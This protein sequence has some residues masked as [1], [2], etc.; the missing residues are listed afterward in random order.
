[1]NCTACGAR[2][3]DKTTRCP[4]CGQEQHPHRRQFSYGKTSLILG[5][6]GIIMVVFILL[7]FRLFGSDAFSFAQFISNILILLAALSIILG[8]FALFGKTKDSDGLIGMIL[9]FCLII[10]LAFGLSLASSITF[11]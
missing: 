7:L 9:G 2:L 6:V 8:A 5:L 1:M 4:F 11:H 3:P 10:G